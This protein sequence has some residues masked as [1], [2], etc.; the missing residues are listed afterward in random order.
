MS[1][2]A[3]VVH[4]HLV[5]LHL[6]GHDSVLDDSCRFEWCWRRANREARVLTS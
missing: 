1:L 6:P 3:A 5:V 2:V 4:G